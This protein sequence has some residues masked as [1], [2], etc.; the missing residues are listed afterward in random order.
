MEATPG[1]EPG[2]RI[3][4]LGFGGMPCNTDQGKAPRAKI[5]VLI[6]QAFS[7]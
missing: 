1:I 4:R 3:R 5:A 2:L 7:G 6:A